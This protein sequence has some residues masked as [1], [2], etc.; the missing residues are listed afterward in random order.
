MRG[1]T[2]VLVKLGSFAVVMIILTAF[3]FFLFARTQT[4]ATTSYSA[5]FADASR[6]RTGDTVRI[7]G[8]R[9]GTVKDVR[10]DADHRVTVKFDADKK[11]QLTS[12]TRAAVRYLN[13]VGDRYLELSDGPG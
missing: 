6:L 4:A 8:I 10:L 11:V 12:G 2:G 13:L 5:I 3:L 9:V 1:L 7:A